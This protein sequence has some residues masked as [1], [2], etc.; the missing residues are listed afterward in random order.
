MASLTDPDLLRNDRV[1][2]LD[3]RP[4]V[5]RGEEPFDTIQQHLEALESDRT[6]LLVAPFDPRPLKQYVT[7]QGFVF[8]YREPEET[9]TWMAIYRGE[10]KTAP[11]VAGNGP[12][13]AIP[14]PGGFVYVLD[15]RELPPPEPLEWTSEVLETLNEGDR[16]IQHNDR[17]PALL[18]DNLEGYDWVLHENEESVR[19]EFT[20]TD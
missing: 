9:M 12:A 6:L 16:L 2:V 8:D 11:E 7:R 10:E 14:V 19:V 5:N 4:I 3:V 18:L 17:K 1:E 13:T 20:R 15:C